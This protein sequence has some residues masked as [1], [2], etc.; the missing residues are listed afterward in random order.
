MVVCIYAWPVSG[1]TSDAFWRWFSLHLYVRLSSTTSDVG[2]ESPAG[3][4]WSGGQQKGDTQSYKETVDG[5]EDGPPTVNCLTVCRQRRWTPRKR[6]LQQRRKAALILSH[7]Q[8][9]TLPHGHPSA[10]ISPVLILFTA[11]SH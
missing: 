10:R 3:F 6:R 7:S 11:S 5:E 2:L 1:R 4:P 8:I 9:Q